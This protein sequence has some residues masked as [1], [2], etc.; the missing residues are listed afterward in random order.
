MKRKPIGN[1]RSGKETQVMEK[2]E[3]GGAINH[4]GT[5]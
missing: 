5:Q 3:D 2:K 1:H 4:L